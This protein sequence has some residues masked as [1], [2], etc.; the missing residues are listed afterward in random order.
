MTDL[1]KKFELF[2]SEL[3]HK[4]RPTEVGLFTFAIFTPR[5]SGAL[6]LFLRRAIR[7][8][9]VIATTTPTSKCRGSGEREGNQA[10]NQNDGFHWGLLINHPMYVVTVDMDQR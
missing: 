7:R 8:V 2:W 1:A 5:I 6:T 3:A 10:K 9:G 4:K